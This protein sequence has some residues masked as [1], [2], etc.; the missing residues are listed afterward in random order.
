MG[1]RDF[2]LF[3][4]ALLG[5]QAWRLLF[6][7]NSLCS[8]LLKAKYFPN[9][10]LLDMVFT[11]NASNTWRAIEYGIELLKKKAQSVVSG[12]AKIYVFGVIIG[13]QE[14]FI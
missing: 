8:R 7:P 3:N 11:G 1:F 13:F 6:F 4:Q 9:G 5:Q 12:M 10:N 14:I 2:R